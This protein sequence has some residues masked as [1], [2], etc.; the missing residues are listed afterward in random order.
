MNGRQ[1]NGR[2]EKT[3]IREKETKGGKERRETKIERCKVG[4]K[5]GEVRQGN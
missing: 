2:D 4:Q 3:E 5:I 1:G